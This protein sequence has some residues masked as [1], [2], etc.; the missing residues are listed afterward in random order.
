MTAKQLRN[1]AAFVLCLGT[2]G[3]FT[4]PKKAAAAPKGECGECIMGAECSAGYA[5]MYCAF[6]CGGMGAGASCGGEGPLG[7]CDH[8][9]VWLDCGEIE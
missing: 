8:S 5:A 4:T 1:R 6:Q 2:V 7:F 3:L 9:L